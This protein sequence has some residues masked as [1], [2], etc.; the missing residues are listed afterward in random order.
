MS[1]IN[2]IL[3][4]QMEYIDMFVAGAI[5]Y[6]ETIKDVVKSMNPDEYQRSMDNI[7][8]LKQFVDELSKW[9]VKGTGIELLQYT[10]DLYEKYVLLDKSV[11]IIM[12]VLQNQSYARLSLYKMSA[13]HGMNVQQDKN[14]TIT[15]YE[16]Y[17][18]MLMSSDEK[19]FNA[20]FAAMDVANNPDVAFGWIIAHDKIINKF[21]IKLIDVVIKLISGEK[22]RRLELIIESQK[23]MLLGT[24]RLNMNNWKGSQAM[25]VRYGLRPMSSSVPP[26]R[27]FEELGAKYDQ[28]S[29]LDENFKALAAVGPGVIYIN[30]ATRNP[31]E[32]DLRGLIDI[33]YITKHDLK[34]NQQSGLTKKIIEK[35]ATTKLLSRGDGPAP[36]VQYP[37]KSDNK[38][39]IIESIDGNTVRLL[40]KNDSHIITSDMVSGLI[41]GLSTRAHQYNSIQAEDIL[42]KCFDP[43]AQMFLQEYEN[44]KHVLPSSE[45]IKAAIMAE[46]TDKFA[47]RLKRSQPRTADEYKRLAVDPQS[48][49]EII[50]RALTRSLNLYG[51][52][53]V[54]YTISYIYKFDVIVR[55]FLK[56]LI[57]NW[58]DTNI[59]E[60]VFKEFEQENLHNY[61]M[62]MYINTTK[63][64][65]DAMDRNNLWTDYDV[66][67]KEYF[68]RKK[69]TVV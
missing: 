39:Y 2:K 47:E 52:N 61:L 1:E 4:D 45:P 25:L 16:K 19:I 41:R 49:N 21:T 69:Q 31:I 20:V 10:M 14:R 64:S 11:A 32:F 8:L 27:L 23:D 35:F 24:T 33:D 30:K 15:Y 29:S 36:I 22:R 68:L 58:L 63:K 55:T 48:T 13:A 65:M 62:E 38:W 3:V 26:S 5:K 44:E 6:I 67:L 50:I 54:E 34:T 60:R 46:L 18:G 43:H 12:S 17:S 42:S 53:S 7:N 66:S 28:K 40:G 51:K 37:P 9:D 56:D 57:L 59:P